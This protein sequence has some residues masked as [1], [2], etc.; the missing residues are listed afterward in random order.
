[1]NKKGLIVII[2]I[3]IIAVGAIL[4]NIFEKPVEKE[5]DNEITISVSEKVTIKD[6]ISQYKSSLKDIDTVIPEFQNLEDGFERSINLKIHNDLNDV[7]VYN[8]AIEGF[9]EEDIGF[10]TYE[11]FYDRYNNGKFLSIVAQQ[12]IHLGDGRPRLQ[13]KCYVIDTES[14]ATV[15]LVDVFENK[16]NYKKA[17]LA[18]INKIADEKDIELIGGNGL[19]ELKDEQAFYIKDNKLIIYYE[20]SEIA[21]TAVGELEFTMPFEMVNEKFV[22]ESGAY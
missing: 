11:T 22:F 4:L 6:K 16:L 2:L 8:T 15:A 21:A 13:K 14:N 7:N 10:F 17:V 3:S 1:M 12:Y 5:P 9:E 19:T 18:E 20:A